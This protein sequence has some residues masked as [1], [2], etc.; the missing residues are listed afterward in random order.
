MYHTEDEERFININSIKK[1]FPHVAFLL[2]LNIIRR[3]LVYKIRAP[4]LL[5]FFFVLIFLIGFNAVDGRPKARRCRV[6]A[7]SPTDQC[8]N[9]M[10][11]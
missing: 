8:R 11:L 5:G 10:I 3:K 9:Y 1:P 7:S 4:G 6:V 2:V